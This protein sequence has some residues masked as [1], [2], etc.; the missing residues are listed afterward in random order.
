MLK[1]TEGVEARTMIKYYLLQQL[2]SF[3]NTRAVLELCADTRK[4][5]MMMITEQKKR[6]L[7]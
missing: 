2:Q 4:I 3:T 6:Q 7:N 5:V 1:K